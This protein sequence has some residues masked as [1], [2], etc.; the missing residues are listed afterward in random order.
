ME[1]RACCVGFALSG[2]ISRVSRL[3]DPIVTLFF[4]SRGGA[5]IFAGMLKGF[6]NNVV[7]ICKFGLRNSSMIILEISRGRFFLFV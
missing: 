3:D 5:G 1:K 7:V 2:R 4:S 6:C